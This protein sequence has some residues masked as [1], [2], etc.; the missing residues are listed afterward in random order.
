[1]YWPIP[2]LGPS[3]GRAVDQALLL[4]KHSFPCA[5]ML[6]SA[7]PRDAAG[8]ERGLREIADLAGMPLVVYLKEEN[9]FGADR[10]AGLDAVARL[11]DSGVCTWIKYA[12]VRPDPLDDPY[13]DGLLTRVPRDRVISG[14]GERPA[15]VHLRDWKLP[16]FTTGSGC[17]AP[18]LSQK[19]LTECMAG[20]FDDA[21][22]IRETFI[23][24]EDL[25]DA[26]GPARVLHHATQLSEVART[27]PIPPY[28]SALTDAQLDQ[29]A[30]V[31]AALTASSCPSR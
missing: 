17:L 8:L 6:P 18:G 16:G 28:V 13:L 11:V 21:E 24:H 14:I 10:D 22:R 19:I 5:M 23:P 3:Y 15:I 26:W 9:N 4:R 2:S 1:N 7:D 20:R 30:P 31:A 25:R 12:V 27:G 29:L